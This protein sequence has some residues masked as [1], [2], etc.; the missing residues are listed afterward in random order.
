MSGRGWLIGALAAAGATTVAVLVVR[1]ARRG[2]LAGPRLPVRRDA[3]AGI[4]GAAGRTA[5]RIADM[6]GQAGEFMRIV[7]TESAVRQSELR[8]RL[9]MEE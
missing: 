4:R 6:V 3:G 1:S 2:E 5:D 8:R 9:G 7:S